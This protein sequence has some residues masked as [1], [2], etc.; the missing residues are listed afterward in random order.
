MAKSHIL[1]MHS[2]AYYG[3]P[4]SREDQSSNGFESDLEMFNATLLLTEKG[5]YRLSYD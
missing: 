1:A 2:Y 5:G 4:I 3:H